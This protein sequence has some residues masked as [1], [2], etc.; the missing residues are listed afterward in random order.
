MIRL[1]LC[2]AALILALITSILAVVRVQPYDDQP[3]REALF[4]ADC[5]PPC[6]I[7]IRP[8]VTTRDEALAILRGHPWIATV[9]TLL[10]ERGLTWTWSG[11]Q[12]AALRGGYTENSILLGE[13]IVRRIDL[14]TG[15]TLAAYLIVIGK[16]DQWE[17]SSWSTGSPATNIFRDYLLQSV[18]YDAY[19]MEVSALGMCPLGLRDRW[20][21]S[22]HISMFA[23]QSRGSFTY[24]HFDPGQVVLHTLSGGC[25]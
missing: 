17:V 20:A 4:S 16:P 21:L 12:P 19:Q 15:E 5:A 22:T 24:N 3:L 14:R 18:T 7:G 11:Q 6:F 23:L 10:G 8:G 25:P 9:D 1:L 13:G 2:V